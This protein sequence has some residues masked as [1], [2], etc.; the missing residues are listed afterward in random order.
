MGKN[1]N[2][3]YTLISPRILFKIL[4]RGDCANLLEQF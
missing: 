4:K 1:N 3:V 2:D